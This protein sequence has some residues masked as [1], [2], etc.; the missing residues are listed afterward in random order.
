MSRFASKLPRLIWI[1]GRCQI[2]RANC[3]SNIFANLNWL[4]FHVAGGP[5]QILEGGPLWPQGKINIFFQCRKYVC[6]QCTNENLEV[7]DTTNRKIGL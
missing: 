2:T 7:R 5:T 4:G 3:C 6:G 1:L